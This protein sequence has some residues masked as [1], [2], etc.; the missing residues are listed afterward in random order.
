SLALSAAYISQ[1][2][3]NGLQGGGY[4]YG[5]FAPTITSSPMLSG[6]VGQLYAYDVEATGTPVPTYSLSTF[7]VGMTINSTTGLINWTPS[8]PGNF[9]VT[10][11]VSN[12]ISP[13]ATQ[14]FTINVTDA[15]TCPP[16]LVSYW[17]LDETSGSTFYDAFANNNGT[18]TSVPTPVTGKVNGAQQ[19]NGSSNRITIPANVIYDWAANASFTLEAWVKH[20]IGSYTAEEVIIARKATDSGLNI[21]LS[22]ASTSVT[23]QVRSKTNQNSSV[24]GTSNLYDGNWHHIVGVKD[25]STS[26]LK[27]YVDG[28]LEGSTNTAYTT[29]FDSPS[30][31]FGIGY[32][33]VTGDESFFNGVIDEVGIYNV[34]LSINEVRQNYASGLQGDGYC[35]FPVAP[36][37][38]SS[39]VTTGMVGSNYSYDVDGTGSPAP[40]FSLDTAPSGMTIHPV[41]GIID[42]IPSSTGDYN[43]TVKAENGV[44]PDATQSFTITVAGAPPCPIG[45]LNYWKLEETSGTVFVD[46]MGLNNA[47]SADR[48]TAITGIVGTGQRFNGTSDQM[49]APRIAA[50]DFAANSSFTFETWIKHPIATPTTVEQVI[51]RKASENQTSI[52]LAFDQSNNISFSV[53]SSS[54]ESF[55]VASTS[56]LFDDDWHHVVAVKDGSLNQL[57]IYVDGV[58]ENTVSATYTSGFTSAT[59]GI[60]IGWRG[61]GDER[62]LNGRI[63]ELAIYNTALNSVLITQ[64]YNNG[65]QFLGYCNIAPSITSSPVLNGAANQL[66]SYVVAATGTP[67]PA[68]SLTTAPSGMTIN[69]TSGLIQWTPSVS[70]AF[71]VT[72]KAANGVDPEATQSFTINVDVAPPC[73][74]GIIS[75]WKLDESAGTTFADYVG[76]NTA[77]TLDRP[78]AITAMV[79]GGQRFNGTSDQITAPRI[80]AYDFAANSSFTIE[81]WFK[82]QAVA[83]SSIEQI[84]GRKAT[85]NLTSIALAFDGSSNLTFSVRSKTGESFS[86]SSSSSL[87]DDVWHHITAVKDG[88][89]NQLRIYIDGVLQNTV[90]AAYTTGFDSPT[91]GISI[92]WRAF[93]DERYLNG[94]LDEL[95]IYGAALDESE[96]TAH[97]YNGLQGVGYCYTNIVPTITSVPEKF[98]VVNQPYVYDVQAAGIP[99]VTYSLTT[100]PSGMTINANSGLI[101]WT[102]VSNGIFDVTVVASNSFGPSSTQSFRIIVQSQGNIAPVITST[103]VTSG[104]IGQLY[105]YDVEASGLPTPTYSLTVSPSGMTINSTSGLIQ[106]T[107]VAGG[108]F[109]VTVV[110]TNGVSPDAQQSFSITV[111]AIQDTAPTIT[112]V[113]DTTGVVGQLY[114]Y[115]V[116]ATGSGVITYSLT[117]NPSG[118]TINASSGLIHWIPSAAGNFNVTVVASNGVNPNASQSFTINVQETPAIPGNLIAVLSSVKLNHVN[119]TWQDNSTNE[120]GF[121][122]E[123]KVGDS[124]SAASYFVI[125]TVSAGVTAFEDSTLADTTTYT[126]RVKAYNLFLESGYSNQASVNTIL[127]SLN[128]PSVLNAN[129]SPSKVNHAL[130]SWQDNSTNELGFILERKVGDS[131]SVEP[132]VLIDSLASN[133]I[134]YEDSTLADTT[135]YT[136]RVKAY[137]SFLESDYSN[138]AS[139]STILSN[140]VSPSGLTAVLSSTKVNRAI[141]AWQDN[142][143][144]ELGFVLERKLGDS[145]SAEPFSILDSLAAGTTSFEDSTLADTTTYTYRV[146]AFNSFTESEY[147]NMASVSTILS[148]ILSPSSLTAVLSLT[149]IN[150]AELNWQD[151]SSNESG[152]ILERKTGDSASVEPYVLLDT[153]TAGVTSFEDS[154]L[155]DTTTYTYRVKAYN[156]FVES[157]Y[158]NIAS[159]TTILSTVASPS[160][161]TAQLSST[162]VNHVELSWLDNSTNELGFILERKTGDSASAAPFVVID[163]LAA[164]VTAFEDSLLSDTTTYTYRLKAFNSFTQSSYSN[165]V[166]I[167]TVISAIVREIGFEIPK[168]YA[169][170]QNYPNPFNPS[171]TIRFGLPTSAHV[172]IKLYNAIGQEVELILNADLDAGVHE[173][174]LNANQ[175]ASGIYFYMIKAQGVNG[176]NFTATKRMILMK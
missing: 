15:P 115:D 140:I 137:N 117:V 74:N 25:G 4:C 56:D 132:F 2:Y 164:D 58:L 83:Y 161:L 65:Y 95:A 47:S 144:N 113:P 79:G 70:G 52:A 64:H 60:S 36:S 23:F 66:Y 174:I 133:T 125:D 78:S 96:I 107:P 102:P 48:P 157:G 170:E 103:P 121:I 3:N 49:N 34:A 101:Q 151:N 109:N 14:S 154:T 11:N 135:T 176:N 106:W 155:S 35:Y 149:K 32:R 100:F 163:T 114:L 98:G 77:T 104:T 21:K 162:K 63:D 13:D 61:V 73:P 51:G 8:T 29:G 43:V 80:A 82:H 72:V 131:S 67:A 141:V 156:L 122:L 38:T 86:V 116:Q 45:M 50:Y 167:T 27:L 26:Q 168:D 89:L 57:R 148:S 136:Y 138:V 111:P 55:S 145:G 142:S 1:H 119:L 7:P 171:T 59:A 173:T 12:G 62:Y 127:S 110:A 68:F 30:A 39:P 124:T 94:R 90:S 128:A 69:S 33:P 37:I 130:L 5:G 31:D 175:L 152:F 139:V 42:W 28:E 24:T 10:V 84:F 143:T 88:T 166:S 159:V 41:T 9:D 76:G 108:T 18:S 118:M 44:S 129:L 85:D 17:K 40:L 22:F 20:P 19:F 16:G 87:Y 92:G 158:S 71:N 99:A 97:Y 81:T 123:R 54:G 53:R 165:L 146:K 172:E 75:Y 134:S 169:L 91:A 150:H 147:S 93:G 105:S 153:L 112:S 46:N 160:N 126:Y 6:V 120:L